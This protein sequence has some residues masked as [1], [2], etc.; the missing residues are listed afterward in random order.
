[1]RKFTALE[2]DSRV[3]PCVYFDTFLQQHIRDTTF[4]TMNYTCLHYIRY[5]MTELMLSYNVRVRY[6][7][8]R[9]CRTRCYQLDHPPNSHPR[10]TV[11]LT[12]IG[13]GTNTSSY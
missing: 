13:I 4:L 1:M 10:S 11:G 2:A 9:V 6:K 5:Y 12:A 8:L 3:I 7:R